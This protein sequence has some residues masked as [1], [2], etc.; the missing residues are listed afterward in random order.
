[1][2]IGGSI[3][4]DVVVNLDVWKKLPPDIQKIMEEAGKDTEQ[5]NINYID[6]VCWVGAREIER[7][8]GEIVASEAFTDEEKTVDFRA[9]LTK[10]KAARP[11]FLYL[12]NY[13]AAV[14]VILDQ[15][16]ELGLKIPSGG[17][18]GWD[19]PKLVE[20]G[21]NSV[22]GGVFSNHFSKEDPS[23]E[24]QG[25]VSKYRDRHG[26]DPDALASLAYDA[27]S[28]LLSAIEKAGSLEGAV[29]RDALENIQINGATGKISFD[30]NRNPIKSA[31]ILEI[32]NGQQQ[33]LTT[34]NP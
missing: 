18:D 20:I 8:G 10:I 23:S 6:H 13:Y 1:M 28:V 33:Y 7:L 31:V 14:A 17:G 30:E 21:G 16:I 32:K 26:A 12:P 29:I 9:Q 11:E 15:A 4:S 25:F 2:S 5:F 24:V 34:V 27:A 3:T 19:S 22:E